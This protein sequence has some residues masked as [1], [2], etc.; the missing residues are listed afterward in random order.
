PKPS[1]PRFNST[2]RVDFNAANVISPPVPAS[3]P[4]S[5]VSF[6]SRS[7]ISVASTSRTDDRRDSGATELPPSMGTGS[8]QHQRHGSSAS[9]NLS[10]DQPQSPEVDEHHQVRAEAKSN[11]KV[12]TSS[13]GQDVITDRTE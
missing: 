10:D 7:S 11:R 3:P 13:E 12:S 6:S 2:A 4:I 9:V 8:P 1:R 5:A